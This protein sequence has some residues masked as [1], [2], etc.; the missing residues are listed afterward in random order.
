MEDTLRTIRWYNDFMKENVGNLESSKP[1]ENSPQV[2]PYNIA[3]ESGLQLLKKKTSKEKSATDLVDGHLSENLNDLREIARIASFATGRLKEYGKKLERSKD[4]RAEVVKHTEELL[5]RVFEKCLSL[6]EFADVV[7]RNTKI[8]K[9]ADDKQKIEWHK[10]AL[11]QLQNELPELLD[12]LRDIP[13]ESGF[14]PKTIRNAIKRTLGSITAVGILGT[15]LSGDIPVKEESFSDKIPE[16]LRHHGK[17]APEKKGAGASLFRPKEGANY[18]PTLGAG[19]EGEPGKFGAPE[20]IARI[21]ER[22]FSRIDDPLWITDLA[23]R[24][25]EDSF[26]TIEPKLVAEDGRVQADVELKPMSVQ[27]GYEIALP[28][29]VGFVAGEIKTKPEVSFTVN[30]NASAITFHED[31]NPVS[32]SYKVFS[33]KKEYP[34]K[35]YAGA[36]LNRTEQ[37]QEVIKRLSI[38]RNSEVSKVLDNHLLNFTYIVSNE[39]Q[40]ILDQMPGTIEEKVGAIEIGSCNTLSAYAAGLLTDA[41]KDAFVGN[42]FLETQNFIDGVRPHSKLILFTDNGKPVSYETTAPTKKSYVN[43]VFET[44]DKAALENIASMEQSSNDPK[45][46][47]KTYQIFMYKLDEILSKDVY[48]KFKPNEGPREASKSIS[49]ILKS[50][51]KDLENL[52]FNLSGSSISEQIVAGSIMGLPIVLAGL[53]AI[54]GANKALTLAMHKISKKLERDADREAVEAFHSLTENKKTHVREEINEHDEKIILERLERLYKEEPRLEEFYPLQEVMSLGHEEKT[55]YYKLILVAKTFVKE[56]WR[57]FDMA[58]LVVNSFNLRKEFERLKADG[59]SV[60]IWI[61]QIRSN[62]A[63]P[64]RRKE[65]EQALPEKVGGIVTKGTK[66]AIERLDRTNGLDST[67]LFKI[68]GVG[69]ADESQMR[70]KS[71]ASP[72]GGEFHGYLPY[73]PGMD[74][75]AIDWNVYARSDALVVKQYAE[76]KHDKKVPTLDVVIDVTEHLDEELEK[77]VALLLYTQRFKKLDIQ[78]IS[79]TSYD[80][81]VFRLDKNTVS[82]L[83]DEGRGAITYL[84]EKIKKLNLEYNLSSFKKGLQSGARGLKSALRELSPKNLPVSPDATVL[85]IGALGGLNFTKHGTTIDTFL[86]FKK[87]RATEQSE[88]VQ[89]V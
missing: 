70:G 80:R 79:L 87:D 37:I 56:P 36:K 89:G 29:P 58:S 67:T 2:I 22:F 61:D 42:G 11:E 40:T 46:Y 44:E 33:A 8:A 49:E 45:D 51:R 26:Q 25:A 19:I 78:S 24:V 54:A 41:G 82:K 10:L 7:R 84:V 20:P 3:K 28:T 1:S 35:S 77:F 57:M 66:L 18:K 81:V 83:M 60:D 52:D 6:A 86:V 74:T 17:T 4:P 72:R 21:N 27:R 13:I 47:L 23:G 62:Y 48:N 12:K 55:N 75:R 38:A 88:D 5:I 15:I 32:V 34:H 50:V 39:L 64:K 85:G 31:K 14:N 68:L 9:S 76:A 43:L 53:L 65:L 30:E 71:R 59:I 73:S 63:N 16:A 69:P